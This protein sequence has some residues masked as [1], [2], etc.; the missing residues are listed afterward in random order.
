M[1]DITVTKVPKKKIGDK[2]SLHIWICSL[3]F[4]GTVSTVDPFVID[5]KLNL[6]QESSNESVL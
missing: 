4:K 2:A 3:F 1:Y 5:S 6:C